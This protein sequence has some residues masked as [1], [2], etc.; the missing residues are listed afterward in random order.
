MR[1]VEILHLGRQ[2]Y[3]S[4]FAAMK[5][6]TAARGPDTPDQIW[7]V[8]HAPVY[9]QGQA[10]KPEHL[11]NADTGIPVVQIDRGGQITYHGP[12]QLVAYLLVDL[13]R[14]GLFVRELVWRIEQAAIAT[15]AF[16]G[17]GG[18]RHPGEPGIYLSGGVAKGAKIAA[19]GLKISRGCSYHGVSLNVAM[20]LEPFGWINPCGQPGLASIDMMSLGAVSG[21]Q[22]LPDVG[23]RLAEALAAELA[24]GTLAAAAARQSAS[25]GAAATKEMP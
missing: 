10:G 6:Y 16:Y 14:R 21:P 4:C 12:G 11:L 24:A 18:E 9:T 25:A 8:E 17:I 2:D 5:T 7:L 22:D 13:R 19:L 23:E 20:D 15:L 3:A 1:D